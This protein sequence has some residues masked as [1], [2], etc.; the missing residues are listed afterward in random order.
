MKKKISMLD[1]TE[2]EIPEEMFFK[3][4]YNKKT[5]SYGKGHKI[6]SVKYSKEEQV[7]GL[8]YIEIGF[9]GNTT[10]TTS[11]EFDVK[12]GKIRLSDGLAMDDK[13][14]YAIRSEANRLLKEHF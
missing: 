7:K 10:I 9:Y 3:L 5:T 1:L 6:M 11:V 12:E 8:N 13:L 2:C 14:F 4:G